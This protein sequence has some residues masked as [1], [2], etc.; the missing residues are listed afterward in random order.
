MSDKYFLDTNIFVYSFDRAAEAKRTRAR[1]LIDA[2]LRT[3]KGIISTQVLQE[4]LNVASTKFERSLSMQDCYRYLDSVLAPLCEVFP[5]IALY[6]SALELQADTRYSFYDSLMIAAALHADCD[7]LYSE[8][9][10]D[11]HNV[12]G[13]TIKNPFQPSV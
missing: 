10:R 4:F 7:T 12:R 9:L 6:R 1:A 2:A 11:G 3:Q 5:S 8:D 13:V